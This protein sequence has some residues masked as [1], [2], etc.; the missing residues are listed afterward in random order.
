MAQPESEPT[1]VPGQRDI[2]DG[3]PH[4]NYLDWERG[5]SPKKGVLV[6]QEKKLMFAETSSTSSTTKTNNSV[7]KRIIL[8]IR[9]KTLLVYQSDRC[10]NCPGTI[11]LIKTSS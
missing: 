11:P 1:S 9:E 5:S 3:Q 7:R 2:H 4:Q 6:R 8:C 10:K